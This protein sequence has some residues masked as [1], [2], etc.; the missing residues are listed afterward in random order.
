VARVNIINNVRTES[1]WK[2]VAIEPTAG[3]MIKASIVNRD[4]TNRINGC[5]QHFTSVHAIPYL[6]Y[7]LT[8]FCSPGKTCGRRCIVY[9]KCVLTDSSRAFGAPSGKFFQVIHLLISVIDAGIVPLVL[10]FG[11]IQCRVSFRQGCVKRGACCRQRRIVATN[12]LRRCGTPA[13]RRSERTVGP[14]LSVA[15]FP[16]NGWL[17]PQHTLPVHPIHPA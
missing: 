16:W 12:C 4:H 1:G 13:R 9:R 7:P 8:H 11:R 14:T 6:A 2:S 5:Q 3:A 17:L 10:T 15:S